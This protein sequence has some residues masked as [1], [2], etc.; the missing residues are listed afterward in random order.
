MD[1]KHP[2]ILVEGPAGDGKSRGV[3]EYVNI[4][5]MENPGIRVL[6]V[7][8]VRADLAESLLFTMEEEVWWPDHPCLANSDQRRENRKSPYVYPNGSKI[9]V[10]GL[11]KDTRL[12]STQFD[13]VV[14]EEAIEITKDN[15][16]NLGR[17]NRNN[18]LIDPDT[19]RPIQ[20]RIAIT[21]PGPEF[22]FLNKLFPPGTRTCPPEP[23]KGRIRLLV[24]FED[25]PTITEE[26]LDVLRS[27]EGVPYRRLYLGDWIAESGQILSMYDPAVHVID[28]LEYPEFEY[29]VAAKDFGYRNPGWFGVFGVDRDLCMV[30]VAE[31]Y[32]QGVPLD[33]WAEWIEELHGEFRLTRG[34]CDSAEPRSIDFLNDRIGVPVGRDVERIFQPADKSRGKLFGLN[35][36]RDYLWIPPQGPPI[37]RFGRD[38]LRHGRD[39]ELDAEGRPCCLVEEIPSYRFRK[40]ADDKENKET[41]DPACANHGCDGIEY[42]SVWHWKKNLTPIKAEHEYPP[43]T[44][45][46][47]LRHSEKMRNARRGSYYTRH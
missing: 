23:H 21:N 8:K 18:K 2:E 42:L 30:M 47:L 3:A 28:E 15:W 35:Q 19:G 27:M 24:R 20:Q 9:Y 22:H 33:Q 6:F 45:G 36:V 16:H 31:I 13:I 10:G 1:C 25:N 14:V 40:Y 46:H 7:R 34:V 41:P 4:R 12:F 11:D 26:Y 39:P 37:L 17:C 29:Y 43:G 44:V 38:V 32:R 5:S